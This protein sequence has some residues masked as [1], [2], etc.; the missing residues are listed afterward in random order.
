MIEAYG[1]KGVKSVFWYET[2]KNQS[3]FERF[4]DKNSGDV[5]VYGIRELE[6]SK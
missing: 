4:V 5:E 6:E 1:V 3:A 2:F